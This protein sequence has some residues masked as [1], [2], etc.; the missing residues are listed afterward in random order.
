MTLSARDGSLGSVKLYASSQPAS[1]GKV[2]PSSRGGCL[3]QGDVEELA[4]VADTLPAPA[5]LRLLVREALS[6]GK[7]A[8]LRDE[9]VKQMRRRYL[10]GY[11]AGPRE[12]TVTMPAGIV[13]LF[14]L[15]ADYPMV[16]I[17]FSERVDVMSSSEL[18]E[19]MCLSFSLCAC[20]TKRTRETLFV[21]LFALSGGV[22]VGLP[23]VCRGGW[24]HGVCEGWAAQVFLTGSHGID[25]RMSQHIKPRE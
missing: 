6:R 1:E 7:C 17:T 23:I 25:C 11:R 19:H 24:N 22:H 18:L 4:S 2:I 14:R 15:H 16:T 21:N 9:H 12:V 3:T 5:N 20:G 13:A 10:I 8:A